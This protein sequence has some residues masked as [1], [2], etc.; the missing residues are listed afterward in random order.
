[1]QTHSEISQSLASCSPVFCEH[2]LVQD[3]SR[4]ANISYVQACNAISSSA[5]TSS[6]SKEE[7]AAK[8]KIGLTQAAQTIRVTTQKGIRNAIHPIQRRF[9]TQQAQ[10]RYNQLGSR[11]G[12]F[13]TDTMF[14][15]IKSTRRNTC[16]QIFADDAGFERVFPLQSKSQAG[17]ALLELIR[18]IGIP[19]ALHSDDARE[20]R[21]GKWKEIES[22]YQI[23]HTLTEPYTPAQNRA[24]GSIRELKKHT[25][26][27]LASTK[28]P[29]KLWDYCIVYDAEIRA[30]TA[31]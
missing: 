15:K 16:A 12:R 28:T 21:F 6:T 25:L 27:R 3:V 11:H 4:V 30:L 23:K 2:T 22:K 20:L 8:W 10:L 24:E 13:Y 9:C 19:A 17:D 1:M 18:D 29:T 26:R 5:R 14:S 7:L 31:S